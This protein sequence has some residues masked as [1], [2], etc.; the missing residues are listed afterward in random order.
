M[1]C[2]LNID[3]YG[4]RPYC[5]SSCV[6]YDNG[7]VVEDGYERNWGGG[8]INDVV[9]HLAT[10]ELPFG[11][12]GASG[13]GAYHGKFGFDAF[14]HQKSILDKKNWFDLPIKY[15]PYNKL[16]DCLLRLFLN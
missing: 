4:E 3:K 6:F 15:Q 11:G 12:C 5:H 1:I 13:M 7:E 14:S 9:L 16:Y 2:P 10:P 8:C